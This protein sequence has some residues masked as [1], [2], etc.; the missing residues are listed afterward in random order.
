MDLDWLET[1]IEEVYDELIDSNEAFDAT[2]A[3]KVEEI[4]KRQEER[5]TA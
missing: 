1:A 4:K 5:A 2:L 3:K